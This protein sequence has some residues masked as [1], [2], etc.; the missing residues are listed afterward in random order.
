MTKREKIL[1][2]IVVGVLALVGLRTLKSKYDTMLTARRAALAAAEQQLRD[3][4]LNLERGVIA[5]EHMAEWQAQSLPANPEVAQSLYSTGLMDRCKAAGLAVDDIQPK[6]HPSAPEPY[7]G[8]GYKITARGT[9]KSLVALLY[10]FYRS[11]LQQQITR[12]QLRPSSDPSQLAI[13]LEVEALAL[14]GSTNDTIPTGTTD[15]L[16]DRT[17]ADYATDIVG[18][19][20]FAVYTPPRP[21]PAPTV[22]ATPPAPPPFDDAK[23]AY[24]TGIVQVNGRLQAWIT[25]RT[26][27]EVLRLFEGDPV[28]VGQLE[29]K[30][31]S[32]GP[33]TVVVETGD[34]QTR[35]DLG[36]NLREGTAVPKTEAG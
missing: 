5:V 4:N 1:A 26:T 14:P 34:Q 27:G 21:V 19:N 29:G 28:K 8:I 32:I 23:H 9:I 30:I 18:R 11:P 12:M 17:A 10:D 35:I 22:R 15:R 2:A 36:K 25:V 33:R 24:V 13:T 3:A 31:V 7:A 20:L 16:G 6:Q